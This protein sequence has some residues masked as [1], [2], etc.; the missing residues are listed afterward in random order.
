M[1]GRPPE[2]TSGPSRGLLHP[3]VAR[4]PLSRSLDRSLTAL[5]VAG[6]MLALIQL[7]L[8]PLDG[9]TGWLPALF[10][11]IFAGYLVAGIVAWYRR[12]SNRMGPLILFTSAT[13]Y[14]AG[15]GN[16]AVPVLEAVG[17]ITATLVLAATIHLLLAFPSGRLHGRG[18]IAIVATG[19]ITALVLRAPVYLFDPAGPSPQLVVADAPGLAHLSA[20]VQ[21][22]VGGAVLVATAIVLARRLRASS[23][24]HRRVLA[25]LFAYGILAVLVLALSANV[26]GRVLQVQATAVAVLQLVVVAGI[27]VA[28]MLGIFSGGFARTGQIEELGSWLG[29]SGDDRTTLTAALAS[30]L[31]DPTL[32]IAYWV[33]QRESFVNAEGMPIT[34]AS[35]L[36]GSGAQPSGTSE[37]GAQP[38]G[39]S[40]WAAQPSG[41][42]E[43]GAQRSGS[44]ASGAKPAGAPA[45]A[46]PASGALAAGALAAGIARASV[47]IELRGAPVAAIS[48][49]T[50]LVDDPESVRAA[51]RIVAILLE[52]E[53]LLAELRAGRRA[54]QHSRERLVDADDRGRRR[55]AQD[56]HD[57]LQ[58]QLVLLSVEAQQLANALAIKESRAAADD[59]APATHLR[60]GIDGAASALRQLV[61]AVMPAALVERGLSAAVDDLADRMPIPTRVELDVEDGSCPPVVERTAYFVIAESLTNAVKYA[62]ATRASVRVAREGTLLHVAVHDNGVGGATAGGG[63]GMR[64]LA[65]RVDVLGGTMRIESE[66]GEGTHIMVEVPCGS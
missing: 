33:P 16:T 34:P 6:A 54:L 46:A 47:E 28:F 22:F 20:I 62:Q 8:L 66:P 23:P 48:Y 36:P 42:S 26:L 32:E 19:Y 52:R 44:S 39:T 4:S 57:G 21:G 60:E 40:E 11:A 29:A 10:P 43:S 2:D 45:S 49:D 15:M 51:G 18:V 59:A 58:V 7:V 14:L 17:T 12:P 5:V 63:A 3:A 56:L 1:T 38:S 61:Q 35:G 31:G 30:T 37:S 64:S 27:P 25:P 65:E 9:P 13:I 53:R 55:L 50:D 41:T 24:A